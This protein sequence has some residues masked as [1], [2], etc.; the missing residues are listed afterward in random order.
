MSAETE[1]TL[2][3]L[4]QLQP[5][6]I[7][8]CGR[9][10]CLPGTGVNLLK[11]I[12]NWATSPAE[13]HRN[14]FWLYGVAGS[15]K[16]TVSTTIANFF[17]QTR[18]LGAHI[19]FDQ[20]EVPERTPSAIIRTLAHQL[21]LFDHRIGQAI[22]TAIDNWPDFMQSS[23]HIQFQKFLVDPLTSLD[24]IQFEGPIIIV[25]D[26]LDECGSAGDRRVLLEVLA[27]KLIKLP[28]AFRFIIAS[29]PDYD[30]RNY[31]ESRSHIQLYELDI[32]SNETRGDVKAFLRYQLGEIA[33]RRINVLL[34]TWPEDYRLRAL[35]KRASG[36]FAWASDICKSI[37]VSDP[38]ERLRVVLENINSDAAPALDAMYVT[39]LE[40]AG[41]LQDANLCAE[42]RALMGTILVS[43]TPLSAAG[44]N[45]LLGLDG[46]A[47]SRLSSVFYGNDT[48][49]TLHPSFDDFITSRAR[50]KYEIWFTYLTSQN[51]QVAARCLDRLD[52]FLIYNICDLQ[53]TVAPN[54]TFFPE[55]IVYACCYWV[56]H[57]CLTEDASPIANK[58][59]AYLFK[60][61][62]NWLEAM[63]ILNR[64]R[65]TLEMLGRLRDWHRVRHHYLPV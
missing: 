28:S 23:A 50:C 8:P 37:D 13:Q 43:K 59:E 36:L 42:F 33:R 47:I 31:F 51:L 32:G 55:D 40:N 24:I 61:L 35:V 18:R 60:H 52:Q 65:E 53:P 5:L 45:S 11:S 30:I 63:S 25:L 49:H 58:L 10:E 34:D 16:S 46:R 6:T 62:V 7:G 20:T 17:Q 39:A 26:G 22:T 3:K 27:E 1:Q 4:Q 56:D 44:L 19:F 64:S 38:E 48:I 15:G 29:R 21:G 14:I 9:S 2:Q 41:L 57:I 54:A 12:V